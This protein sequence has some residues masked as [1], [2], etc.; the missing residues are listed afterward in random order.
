MYQYVLCNLFRVFG[1]SVSSRRNMYFVIYYIVRCFNLRLCTSVFCEAPLP[2]CMGEVTRFFLAVHLHWRCASCFAKRH[3]PFA[4]LAGMMTSGLLLNVACLG[5]LVSSLR[6]Q[7]FPPV[8]P[9]GFL[10]GDLQLFSWRGSRLAFGFRATGLS[11]R[12][13]GAWFFIRGPSTL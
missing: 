9:A 2:F 1:R 10:L 8:A 5:G 7:G 12:R 13:S 11:T 6:R 3:P 4:R